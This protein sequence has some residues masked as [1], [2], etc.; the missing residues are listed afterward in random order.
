MLLLELIKL[1]VF[2]GQLEDALKE[3]NEVMHCYLFWIF[4]VRLMIIAWLLE[5]A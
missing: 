5:I 4:D 1:K 2:N 3:V